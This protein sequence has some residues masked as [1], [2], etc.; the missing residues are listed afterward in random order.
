MVLA[1]TDL[2]NPVADLC[3]AGQTRSWNLHVVYSTW[4]WGKTVQFQLYHCWVQVQNFV[5]FDLYQL[6]PDVLLRPLHLQ[7]SLYAWY[8]EKNVTKAAALVFYQQTQST[9]DWIP[10][11]FLMGGILKTI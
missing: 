7:C 4:S 2:A 9:P 1:T 10:F 8:C 11:P 3:L 5:D 6:G